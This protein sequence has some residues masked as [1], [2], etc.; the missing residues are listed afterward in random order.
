[1]S[2][3]SS[4]PSG[5]CASE[6]AFSLGATQEIPSL[7]V[8]LYAATLAAES[9]MVRSRAHYPSD[10]VAGAAVSIVV[11]LVAW[12][13]WPP[14]RV[15]GEVGDDVVNTGAGLSGETTAHQH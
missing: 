13:V 2:I 12:K 11:A 6:L 4:F 14:H 10:I 7:I 9:S 1:M 3:T 5:H 8:P 15:A